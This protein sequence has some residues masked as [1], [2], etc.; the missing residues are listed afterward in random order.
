MNNQKKYLIKFIPSGKSI[1][2]SPD[3]NLKQ[4]ILDSGIH[5]DSSCGGVGTCGRCKVRV[6]EGKVNT[7]KS[8]FISSKEKENGY[9]L[10]CLSK[11]ESDLIVEVPRQK[12]AVVKI[13]K[14]RFA[15]IESKIYADISKDELSSVEIKPWI[16]KETIIV[17]KPSLSYG[18]SDLYRLKKSIRN[19]LNL[20]DCMV[21]IHIIKKLPVVL[22][23]KNWEV[24]VTIDRENSTLIDV[25][26]G[27]A[28]GKSYG[29]ALDI[30][31]TS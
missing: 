9:V 4:A 21:P 28:S 12:K 24:A 31:T 23:E 10:S 5:I 16:K 18:T 17:E 7:K 8:K 19:N 11:V 29:L 14:G 6:R 13:E 30:G 26:P 22:R 3:Y 25:K 1:K 27:S 15:D 20:E 2:I